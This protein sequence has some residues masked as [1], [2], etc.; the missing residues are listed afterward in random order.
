M[1]SLVDLTYPSLPKCN[2]AAQHTAIFPP[3][4]EPQTLGDPY[5]PPGQSVVTVY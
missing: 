1:M 3:A 5:T 4:L 2:N